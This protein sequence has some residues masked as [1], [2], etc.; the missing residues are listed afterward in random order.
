MLVVGQ[1]AK[2]IK[3]DRLAE[4]RA[5]PRRD[6]SN[7]ELWVYHNDRTAEMR[8]VRHHQP[9]GLVRPRRPETEGVLR[10]VVA[11]AHWRA[12]ACIVSEIDSFVGFG[13]LLLI[14]AYATGVNVPA[15][16]PNRLCDDALFRVGRRSAPEQ[17]DTGAQDEQP[18]DEREELGD[19]QPLARLC[20]RQQ[21][22]SGAP[23]G[24]RAAA[25]ETENTERDFLPG[26]HWRSP[27]DYWNGSL[28]RPS[29]LRTVSPGSRR[30]RGVARSALR[31]P[32]STTA[33]NPPM[34]PRIMPLITFWTAALL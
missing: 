6:G 24:E 23:H 9:H 14:F 30:F 15:C 5:L 8:Q 12:F 22:H 16:R 1:D 7:L 20:H 26:A 19:L 17:I 10:A 21:D 34:S 32:W 25:T 13:P 31:L 28:M 29:S 2:G 27:F 33:S 11:Q 18:D 3:N 4:L